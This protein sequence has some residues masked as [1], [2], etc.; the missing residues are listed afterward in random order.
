MR[1]I[2][3]VCVTREKDTKR[4]AHWL[5]LRPVVVPRLGPLAAAG[6]SATPT[7]TEALAEIFAAPRA[8]ASTSSLLRG[9]RTREIKQYICLAHLFCSY[10]PSQHRVSRRTLSRECKRWWSPSSLD[11]NV[12]SGSFFCFEHLWRAPAVLRSFTSSRARAWR[13][14]TPTTAERC[15]AQLPRFL[16]WASS[17]GRAGLA[18]SIARGLPKSFPLLTCTGTDWSDSPRTK[19]SESCLDLC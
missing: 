18:T 16:L 6:A 12:L 17:G 10:L 3:S 8:L 14:M 2:S 15:P 1:S 19:K 13:W 4:Q 11:S 9:K 7:V 5:K